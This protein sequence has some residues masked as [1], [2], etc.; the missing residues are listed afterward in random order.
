MGKPRIRIS[1]LMIAV[2]VVA[3]AI[4]GAMMGRRRSVF[5]AL[6]APHAQMEQL[7]ADLA[8]DLD[9]D[10]ASAKSETVTAL[11]PDG[12]AVRFDGHGPGRKLFVGPRLNLPAD[13]DTARRLAAMCRAES[14]RE[15][16]IARRY[17]QAAR[18]PWRFV[19]SEMPAPPSPPA[20]ASSLPTF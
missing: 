4:W 10:P 6:A 12:S 1:A 2:A 19:G 17:E 15:G 9:G 14:A 8:R 20:P 18:H 16:R 13:E 3:L 7:C 5:L 11:L